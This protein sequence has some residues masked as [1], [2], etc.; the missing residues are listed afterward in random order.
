MQHEGGPLTKLT[1]D[2]TTIKQCVAV[3][4]KVSIFKCCLLFLEKAEHACHKQRHT[5]GIRSS[6]VQFLIKS[7][8]KP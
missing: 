1:G 2:V 8:I 5:D 7:E 6:L 4:D 3:Y